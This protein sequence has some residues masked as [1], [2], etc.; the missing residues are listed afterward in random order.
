MSKIHK[1]KCL[2]SLAIKKM[3]I[4]A[5]LK[6]HLTTVRMAIIKS[7]NNNKCWQGCREKGNFV[8]CWWERKLVQPLLKTIWRLF[9]KLKMYLLY[10]VAIPLLEVYLNK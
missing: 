9:K 3:Q 2:P 4:K 7:I 1:K 6:F 5:T 10:D 8:H